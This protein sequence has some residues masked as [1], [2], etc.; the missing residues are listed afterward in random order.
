MKAR[1]DAAQVWPEGSTDRRVELRIAEIREMDLRALRHAG[2][3]FSR[4][5]APETRKAIADHVAAV[6]LGGGSVL[7]LAERSADAVL[8]LLTTEPT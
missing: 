7:D 8:R 6:L 5:T 4:V 1:R 3:V 2:A